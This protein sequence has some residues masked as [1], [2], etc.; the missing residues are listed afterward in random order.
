MDIIEFLEAKTTEGPS[1]TFLVGI[2][3]GGKTAVGVQ[4]YRPGLADGIALLCPGFYPRVSLSFWVECRVLWARGFTPKKLFPVPLSDPTLFTAN[5]KW[6]TFLRE[7]PLSL[8]HVTARFLCMSAVLDF[9]LRGAP[10]R[11]AV[12][13]LLLLAGRDRIIDNEKTRR[14]VDRFAGPTEVIEYPE[15]H[16]TLEFEPDPE[17][18][19]RDLIGWLRRSASS[20]TG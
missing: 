8:R 11:I 2:C 10:K 5:E 20:S 3:W 14:I 13:T 18:H 7:D 4:R 17:K 6:L 9:Y 19:I 1:K 16:H 15:A 12:P